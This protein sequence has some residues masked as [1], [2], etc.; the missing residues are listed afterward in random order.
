M[1]VLAARRTP[2]SRRCPAARRHSASSTPAAARPSR[3]RRRTP[4]SVTSVSARAEAARGA[5]LA[6]TGVRTPGRGE[7][8]APDVALRPPWNEPAT[9]PHPARQAPLTST[10]PSPGDT[11]PH[12]DHEEPTAAEPHAGRS[13][14]LSSGPAIED[15]LGSRCRPR[16]TRGEER[17]VVPERSPAKHRPAKPTRSRPAGCSLAHRQARRRQERPFGCRPDAPQRRPAAPRGRRPCS[18]ARGSINAPVVVAEIYEPGPCRGSSFPLP[19]PEVAAATRP[20]WPA[21]EPVSLAPGC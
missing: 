20:A 12:E 11:N 7:P 14:R 10:P 17:R 18:A 21:N 4:S 9:T 13:R 2:P 16:R 1:P 15:H 19:S 6:T 8:G 5:G 3:G